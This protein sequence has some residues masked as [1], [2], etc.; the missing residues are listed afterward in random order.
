MIEAEFGIRPF[1]GPEVI[2]CRLTHASYALHGPIGGD[3]PDPGDGI[4]L[5]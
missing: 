5:R 1:E 3:K 4:G 2:S